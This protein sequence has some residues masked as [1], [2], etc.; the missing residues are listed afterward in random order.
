M[1]QHSWSKLRFLLLMH[2]KKDKTFYSTNVLTT[3]AALKY[4]KLLKLKR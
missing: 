3:T 2:G 4:M 1:V